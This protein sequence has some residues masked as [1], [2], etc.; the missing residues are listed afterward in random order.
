MAG[1]QGTSSQKDKGID[2]THS[3]D[4]GMEVVESDPVL[5]TPAVSDNPRKR[6]DPETG[7]SPHEDAKRTNQGNGANEAAD[8]EVSSRNHI[9]K[10]W[11]FKLIKKS[12]GGFQN[13]KKVVDSFREKGKDVNFKNVRLTQSKKIIL[14][15]VDDHQEAR[16]FNS[17]NKHLPEVANDLGIELMID[18]FTPR[19]ARVDPIKSQVIMR[20]VPNFITEEDI[21]EELEA[22]YG[23]DKIKKVYRVISGANSEPTSL[24]RAMCV[25]EEM[26]NNIIK[27]GLLMCGVSLRP[28]A[29]LSFPKVMRCFKCQEL[30]HTQSTCPNQLKCGKC[31]EEHDT[32]ECQ[33]NDRH[34]WKCANC[35]GTHAAWYHGCPTI[36]E[37][38]QDNL[39]QEQ[40][41]QQSKTNARSQRTQRLTAP[42]LGA[43]NTPLPRFVTPGL[44]FAG[45]T[46]PQSPIK[47]VVTN[48]SRISGDLVN[49]IS[50][51]EKTFKTEMETL[52]REMKT[53]KEENTSLK[54]G[55][56]AFISVIQNLTREV[57]EMKA[58]N[59]KMRDRQITTHTEYQKISRDMKEMKDATTK[60]KEGIK[61][62]EDVVNKNAMQLT[63]VNIKTTTIKEKVSEV[64]EKVSAITEIPDKLDFQH[65][66]T[67]TDL[68]WISAFMSNMTNDQA[69]KAALQPRIKGTEFEASLKTYNR[70]S[71]DGNVSS[72][73]RTEPKQTTI[74]QNGH[75]R[76]GLQ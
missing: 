19:P 17:L 71:Q 13:P 14:L 20:N 69:L 37:H 51:M 74:K 62:I 3:E 70:K 56:N 34:K 35:L 39:A 43:P 68:K 44:S 18:F 16:I 54:E 27:D 65:E 72:G 61:I 73:P 9:S 5:S 47:P 29:A 15:L 2:S 50:M 10:R 24:V 40:A 11:S 28:E 36:M 67:N 30:G 63:T 48:M 55:Q 60:M 6:D 12:A 76:K 22:K 46:N 4:K 21:K 59:M 75:M 49:S 38:T 33:V 41:K 45:A 52:H 31:S 1:V 64:T 32:R 42:V 23:G 8:T 25:D 26:A 58:E 57:N 7:H 66:V 53:M